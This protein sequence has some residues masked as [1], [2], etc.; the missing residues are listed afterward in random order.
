MVDYESEEIR[1]K[2]RTLYHKAFFL[3]TV[4]L[5]YLIVGAVVFQLIEHG[6][7]EH[8]IDH[9]TEELDEERAELLK[10]FIL[11]LKQL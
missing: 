6:G 8:A 5:V 3:F 7:R 1:D 9:A 10:V 11:L 4:L 2:L